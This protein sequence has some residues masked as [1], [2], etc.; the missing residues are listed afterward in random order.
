M[1][2]NVFGLDRNGFRALVLLPTRRHHILLAKNLAFSP[3]VAVTPVAM[4]I[5]L[6][7]FVRLPWEAFLAGLLQAGVAFLLFSLMCNL[8]SILAPFR[9]RPRHAQGQEAQGRLSSS[10]CSSRCSVCR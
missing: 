4:L 10:R 8:L 9:H 1:M 3:F 5:A 7:F 6:K 2:S